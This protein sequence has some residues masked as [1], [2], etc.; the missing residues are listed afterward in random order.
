MLAAMGCSGRCLATAVLQVVAQCMI[1]SEC[2]Y[3]CDGCVSNHADH[4]KH[5]ALFDNK[6]INMALVGGNMKCSLSFSQVR[7]G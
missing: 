2:A 1:G 6:M 4:I 7:E 5:E 3:F